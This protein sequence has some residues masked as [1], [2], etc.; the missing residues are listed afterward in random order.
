MATLLKMKGQ[1][2]LCSGEAAKL[3][4]DKRGWRGGWRPQKKRTEGKDVPG[5]KQG[6]WCGAPEKPT[7]K[8]SISNRKALIHVVGSRRPLGIMLKKRQNLSVSPHPIALII[9]CFP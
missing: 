3:G 6:P 1:A 4:R 5:F 8:L 2:Y 7:R 9:L